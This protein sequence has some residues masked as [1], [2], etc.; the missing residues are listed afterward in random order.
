MAKLYKSFRVEIT[1]AQEEPFV[2]VLRAPTD[3]ER[4]NFE[5]E[6]YNMKADDKKSIMQIRVRLFDLLL[7]G[8]EGLDGDDGKPID[9]DRKSEIPQVYKSTTIY[10][11]F[12][13]GTI[14]IKNC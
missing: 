8:V 10:L 7:E 6:R 4:N 13:A 11:K 2:F 3:E 5:I 12:E 1:E 14:N 9:L